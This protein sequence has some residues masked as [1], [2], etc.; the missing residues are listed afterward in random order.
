MESVNFNDI[1][2]IYEDNHLLVVN[3]PINLLSQADISKDI[4]LL[5]LM[6]EY[7]RTT[8]N[9]PG[10]A[11]LGLVHR[12]D[13]MTGGVMVFA[14]TSKAASRLSN[15][16]RLNKWKKGYYAI[17][18]KTNITKN[19]TLT[20]YLIKNNQTNTSSVTNKNNKQA[21]KAILKYQVIGEYN[22][23]SLLDIDLITGRHHQIRV[24]LAHRQIPII[25]DHRY[26]KQARANEPL[27]LF[28]YKLTII[29]PTL[30]KPMTFIA[31]PPQAWNIDKYK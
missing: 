6:K 9:K 11:Y 28:A 10:A 7:I 25:D 16:I 21:K 27:K 13:R 19:A 30:K 24:Q 3:K 2:I 17:V 14:K 12:L 23:Q 4:D 1:E 29:H 22:K 5:N 8:Y 15:Q 26:N 18:N 20:D 31:K